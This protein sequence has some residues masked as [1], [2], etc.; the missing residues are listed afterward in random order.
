ML[1][2]PKVDANLKEKLRL[3]WSAR[4]FGVQELGLR[5]GDAFTRFVDLHGEAVAWNVSAA[6]KDKLVPYYHRFPIT[7]AVPYLGFFRKEDAL[8][9][10]QHL[11]SLGLDTYLRGVAG[12][13]T[14]GYTSDPIYSSMLEGSD[15]RIVEVVLHEML[16]GTVFLPGRAEWNESFATFVGLHGAALFFESH[17]DPEIGRRLIDKAVDRE[18]SQEQFAHFLEPFLKELE[19]LYR[20]PV[21]RDEKLSKRVEIF[22]RAQKEYERVFPAPPG[23]RSSFVEQP[24]NN[25]MLLSF[26][27]YHRATF[28]H[29]QMYQRVFRDLAA[30]IRLYKHAAEDRDDP[31]DYLRSLV[32]ST[33]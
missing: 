17:G 22:T 6:P 24:L 28:T 29:E 11:R 13:S 33:R 30:M 9:E 12:Y 18:K 16:H 20:S 27:I 7:G 4:E 14:L 3:A 32:E 8:K 31:I 23:F 5:G 25:A 21:T 1:S 2:D 10:E 15:A 19:A 26:S